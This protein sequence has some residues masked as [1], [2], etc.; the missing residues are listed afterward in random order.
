MGNLN[1]DLRPDILFTLKSVSGEAYEFSLVPLKQKRAAEIFHVSV[2]TLMQ[3]LSGLAGIAT[4]TVGSI[5]KGAMI[6]QALGSIK[7]NITFEDVWFLAEA[8]TKGATVNDKPFSMETAPMITTDPYLMYLIIF[9]GIKHNWPAV[10]T[11]LEGALSGLPEAIQSEVKV[12]LDK[13]Q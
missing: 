9:H 4:S 2:V 10:F 13:V 7:S 12:H 8:L 3:S 6:Q 11:K 1:T 5:D